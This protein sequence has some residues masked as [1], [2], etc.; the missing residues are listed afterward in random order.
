MAN[1]RLLS[2]LVA[3]LVLWSF[4][5]IAVATPVVDDEIPQADS[6]VVRFNPPQLIEAASKG[7][8]IDY[9]LDNEVYKDVI[10]VGIAS[11]D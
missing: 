3:G 8:E 2:A 10:K 1:Q 11:T 4:E 5:Q 7:R 6:S 9:R